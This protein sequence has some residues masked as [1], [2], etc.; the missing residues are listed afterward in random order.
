MSHYCDKTCKHPEPP[1]A[2]EAEL[3][4]IRTLLSDELGKMIAGWLEEYYRT[5]AVNRLYVSG[6]H[7]VADKLRDYLLSGTEGK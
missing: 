4:R 7:Y 6:A 3:S 2:A 5:P 1:S